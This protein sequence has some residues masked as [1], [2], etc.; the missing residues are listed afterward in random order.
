MKNE[1]EKITQDVGEITKLVKNLD[2]EDIPVLGEI[3]NILSDIE[4]TELNGTQTPFKSVVS[5][6]KGYMGKLILEEETDPL[7]V[8][9]GTEVL[10]GIILSASSGNDFS[11]DIDDVMQSLRFNGDTTLETSKHDDAQKSGDDEL[12]GDVMPSEISFDEEDISI[13]K[14]FIIESRDNLENIEIK[15]IDLEQNPRDKDIINE[16][17]RPF[18]TI[19]G[20]SGFLDLKRI[21]IL[22]HKTE[23]LLDSARRGEIIINAMI[24]DVIL[25]SVDALGKMLNS[26]ENAIDAGQNSFE[27]TLNIKLLLT[28]IDQ[29]VSDSD[30]AKGKPLGKIL[31]ESGNL[32]EEKL[33]KALN[34]QKT[35]PQKK[36]G[37]ILIHENIVESK[38]VISAIRHQKS[39]Q[40]GAP[41][42]KVDTIKL[43]NLVDLTGELVIAQSMI[44]Q[45]L[46]KFAA[47]DQK[48]YQNMNQLG[49]I[50]SGL[51]K[52]AMSMRM[53]PIGSTFQKMVRLVRD[54]SKNSGRILDLKMSG[55]ETEI[56]RNV[57]DALYEPMVHMIR[58]SVDHGMELPEEREKKGKKRNGYIHLRAYH[59]GGNIVIEL[60]DDGKGLDKEKILEKAI[61]QNIIDKN[62]VLSDPEI[63]DLIMQPGFSTAEKIT[64]IS[65]RGVGMDVVKKTIEGLRGRLE[66]QSTEGKGSTFIISLPLTLAIIEGML[67]RVGVEKYIIPTLA[68]LESFKPNPRDYFTVEGKGEMIKFRDKIVPLIRLDRIFEISAD[69]Q[70]PWDGIVVVVENKYEKRGLLIDELLGKD[71]FVI[72]SLG[73]SL[74]GIQG[75]AGGSIMGDGRIGLILDMEGLFKA[76]FE[77]G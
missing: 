72:K 71:E 31:I 7:P 18:H 58:N 13:L 50:V 69:S 21:N 42:V 6:I 56:D 23:N 19:K 8:V 61:S 76:C 62:D 10:R 67:I 28:Q 38:N 52:T 9:R 46:N 75:L 14:D 73:E 26:I 36:L 43:D 16:I 15:L 34:I 4:E 25:E 27:E 5:A 60:E 49:Q 59:K 29:A 39:S 68:I 74:K 53:I 32:D 48:F 1:I 41:Q 65:G 64:D 20:V 24:T 54:L 12:S 37:E 30:A 66:I 57:V 47:Q 77:R 45:N 55:E 11:F 33:Q 63:F 35:N 40:Q 51:Q 22:A 3:L 2:V 17:F 70:N 44:R